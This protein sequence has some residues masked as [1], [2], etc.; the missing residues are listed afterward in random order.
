MKGMSSGIRMVRLVGEETEA[1]GIRRAVRRWM[2]AGGNSGERRVEG[3]WQVKN[4]IRNMAL[5]D[6]NHFRLNLK[7]FENS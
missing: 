2:A 3:L 7:N 4:I 6:V 5:D 1:V